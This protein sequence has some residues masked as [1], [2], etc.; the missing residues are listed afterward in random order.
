M[1]SPF[2]AGFMVWVF[3]QV[4]ATLDSHEQSFAVNDSKTT[5]WDVVH[6]WEHPESYSSLCLGK[7]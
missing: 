3:L 5:R 6:A 4:L 7:T 2:V 1:S